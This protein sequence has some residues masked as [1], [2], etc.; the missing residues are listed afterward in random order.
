MI[1]LE[2]YIM[3]EPQNIPIPPTIY[4]AVRHQRPSRSS[5]ESS[6]AASEPHGAESNLTL[7]PT[8]TT[9]TTTTR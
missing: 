5:K 4:N 9:T 1:Y 2:G 6:V 3:I 8:T 7:G